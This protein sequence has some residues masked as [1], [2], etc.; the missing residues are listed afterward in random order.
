MVRLCGTDNRKGT[1]ENRRRQSFPYT[2]IA[3][4]G[5]D[6]KD[7]CEKYGAVMGRKIY[8]GNR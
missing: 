2:Q 5:S 6:I 1:D 7:W 8:K 3:G 4:R